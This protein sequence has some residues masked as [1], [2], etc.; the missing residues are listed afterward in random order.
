MCV[1]VPHHRPETA[2]ACPGLAVYRLAQLSQDTRFSPRH[3]DWS[4]PPL[5][6][7]PQPFEPMALST[8]CP[9]ALQ[10]RGSTAA[11]ACAERRRRATSSIGRADSSGSA[12]GWRP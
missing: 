5:P 6:L 3:L 12:C 1:S 11:A 10:L 8:H 2:R 9:R 4:M 7:V